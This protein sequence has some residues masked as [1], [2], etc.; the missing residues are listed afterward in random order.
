MKRALM[1]AVL[2]LVV[3][4]GAEAQIPE[5][6]E[7]LQVLPQTTTRPELVA[8]MR[9]FATALGVRCVHCHVGEDS[10]NLTA[11]SSRMNG[12]PSARRAR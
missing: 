11:T 4:A 1:S 12:R 5:R 3:A 2:V 9:S 6:F 10:P 8:V 7:N